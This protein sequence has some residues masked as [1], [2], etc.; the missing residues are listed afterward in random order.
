MEFKR[1]KATANERVNV[2]SG[3]GTHFEQTGILKTGEV[4]DVIGKDMDPNDVLW[5]QFKDG[6][7]CSKYMTIGEIEPNKKIKSRK[8]NSGRALF[9][10]AS[11]TGFSTDRLSSAI[12]NVGTSSINGANITSSLENMLVGSMGESVGQWYKRRIFATPHQFLDTTDIRAK[13]NTTLSNLGRIYASNILSEMPVLSMMPC[14]PSYLPNLSEEKKKQMFESMIEKIKESGNNEL[15]DD[16]SSGIVNGAQTR[17]FGTDVDFVE[18]MKYVNFLCRG[19]AIFMGLGNKTVPGSQRTYASYNWAHWRLQNQIDNSSNFASDQQGKVTARGTLEERA[20]QIKEWASDKMKKLEN[21]LFEDGKMIDIFDNITLDEYYVDFYVTPSSSYSESFSNQTEQ[22]KFA[23][24]LQSGSDL[25]KEIQFAMGASALSQTDIAQSIANAGGE[26]QK[27]MAQYS[28]ADNGFFSRLLQD[29]QAIISGSNI[30]FPDIWR[31]SDR[32]PSYHA[33]IKL[34][35]PYGTPEA[36]YL[37]CLV[38]MFHLM[39][40]SLPRQTSVNSY[41]TPFLVKAHMNKWFSIEMGIIDTFEIQKS[42]W[43]SNGWPTELTISLSIRDLYSKLAISKTDSI[44]SALCAIHNQALLEFM[45]VACGLDMKST[46]WKKKFEMITGLLSNSVSDLIEN[47]ND[48]MQ[49]EFVNAQ[50]NVLG[51]FG[52][53]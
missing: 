16:L 13:P 39:A 20:S 36:I 38:P 31:D 43:T 37:N 19:A 35:S 26:I 6:Y 25:I 50:L 52:K 47:T 49:Q 41:G 14:R 9:T 22:S 40:F 23:S 21:L 24:A 46:E 33:E 17:Y 51:A 11:D 12:G 29:A 42:G 44:S 48:L 28:G 7:V 27:K 8:G 53:V 15:L 34:V 3:A 2:R 45:S 32:S 4:I 30:I 18:Y 10:P 5:F 1:F